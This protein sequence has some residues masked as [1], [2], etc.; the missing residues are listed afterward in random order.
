MP[1]FNND[2]TMTSYSGSGFNFS[3]VDI[4]NHLQASEYTLVSLAADRSSSVAGFAT[5]IEGC[6]KTSFEG[7]QDSPRVDNLMARLTCFN[8][9]V[10]EIHGFRHLTDCPLALYVNFL[11]AGGTTSLYDA[12][13]DAIDSV[14]TY[15]KA[16]QDQ[17]YTAN[18]LV[19]IITD[20]E[21][22]G[23]TFSVN[24]VK[25]A[26]DKA[27]SSEA[28]ESVLTILIGINVTNPAMEQYLA[29][30]KTDAG[31]D[32]FIAAKDASPKTFAKIANFISKS[33]SSQSQALRSGSA[34]QPITF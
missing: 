31:I 29:K 13:V 26:L 11:R 1:L 5:E 3:G 2:D 6:I 4:N 34:S 10:E 14:A 32:Q 21:D 33:I 23:S 30:F 17:E 9:K 12:S 24:D 25:K 18:G 15:G 16:L 8:Q 27:R 7:C 20:G 22:I 28:L 19:V